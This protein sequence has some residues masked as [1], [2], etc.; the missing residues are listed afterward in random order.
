MSARPQSPERRLDS[1]RGR[2]APDSRP[3]RPSGRA[4]SGPGSCRAARRA[5]AASS[6]VSAAI[7]PTVVMPSS[8][9]RAASL[10]PSP[11]S[12]RH[13]RLGSSRSAVSGAVAAV[14]ARRRHGER[15]GGGDRFVGERRAAA[16][17][18]ARSIRGRDGSA[19]AS[20]GC[21]DGSAAPR[22]WRGSLPAVSTC[23]V[24][25]VDGCSASR[26]RRFGASQRIAITASTASIAMIAKCIVVITDVPSV[27]QAGAG[28]GGCGWSSFMTSTVDSARRE[29][30]RARLSVQA[31]RARSRASRC[32][33]GRSRSGNRSRRPRDRRRPAPRRRRRRSR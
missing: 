26:R 18:P 17:R 3:V 4:P 12:M 22:C 11:F 32:R 28:R 5:R 10:G 16:A 23:L 9:S 27:D 6:G 8:A 15:R 33:G 13:R 20:S 2:P 19:D 31:S 30:R 24:M 14:A 29:R 25:V 7:W 1:P 21:A